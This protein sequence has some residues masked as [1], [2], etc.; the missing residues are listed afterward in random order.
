[1][2]TA[3]LGKLSA[4]SVACANALCVGPS[5]HKA[6]AAIDSVRVKLGKVRQLRRMMC[7]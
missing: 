6:I 1:M 7:M 3:R 4:E 5:K 2:L